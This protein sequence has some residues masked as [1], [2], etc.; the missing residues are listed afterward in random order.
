MGRRTMVFDAALRLI[1]ASIVGVTGAFA[2]LLSDL[3]MDLTGIA[4]DC[5]LDDILLVNSPKELRLSDPK[6]SSQ[7]VF[8]LNES[9]WPRLLDPEAL[10]DL[11]R[12]LL[13]VELL[14]VFELALLPPDAVGL[15]RRLRLP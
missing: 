15:R 12:R 8:E 14:R 11:R 5:C 9:V 13:C 10:L 2:S 1:S 3:G 4:L 6:I 7:P